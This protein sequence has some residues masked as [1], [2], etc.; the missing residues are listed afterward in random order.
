MLFVPP[1]SKPD[2][3]DCP[4]YTIDLA[5]NKPTVNLSMCQLGPSY[6]SC[7]QNVKLLEK[8]KWIANYNSRVK[9]REKQLLVSL[10]N[11][12]NG[13]RYIRRKV[14]AQNIIN[15]KFSLGMKVCPF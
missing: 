4:N 13:D 7:F 14:R 6:F 12:K 2:V 10:D 15:L 8:D 5:N 11:K 1:R 9:S 3:M